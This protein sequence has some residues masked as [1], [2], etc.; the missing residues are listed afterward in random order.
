M[1]MMMQK[2]IADCLTISL[3]LFVSYLREEYMLC[4]RYVGAC[5]MIYA[6]DAISSA[7]SWAQTIGAKARTYESAEYIM[8]KAKV[9]YS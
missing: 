6:A 1:N 7:A 3:N 4:M 2:P 9:G 5:D 8:R